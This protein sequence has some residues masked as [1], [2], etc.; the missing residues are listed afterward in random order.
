MRPLVP[1]LL[2]V[3]LLGRVPA[4]SSKGKYSF[5]SMIRFYVTDTFLSPGQV[6]ISRSRAA[7]CRG[8]AA[9]G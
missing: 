3:P 5:T 7:A 6:R 8:S 4:P 1:L 2:V 9:G